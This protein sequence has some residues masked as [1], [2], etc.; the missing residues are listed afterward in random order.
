VRLEST[1][2]NDIV[3]VSD[4]DIDLRASD[5]FQLRN[6]DSDTAEFNETVTL[7]HQRTVT[8]QGSASGLIVESSDDK[9][10]SDYP[11]QLVI[12]RFDEGDGVN[13]AHSNISQRIAS[14]DLTLEAGK[15]TLSLNY[16]DDDNT[17]TENN[18]TTLLKF[19][20][21]TSETADANT[22]S[23]PDTIELGA[24]LD[25]N[26]QNITSTSNGNIVIE[27]DGTGVTNMKRVRLGQD[28][29]GIQIESNNFNDMLATTRQ[30]TSHYSYSLE[31]ASDS[32]ATAIAAGQPGGAFGFT[33][34]SDGLGPF[35]IGSINGVV[36]DEGTPGSAGQNNNGI[37]LYTYEDNSSYAL[38]TVA[39]FRYATSEFM[40]GELT[41][42][43]AS[44]KITIEAPTS[45][46]DI[47]LKTNGS[48]YIILSNLPTS[49]AGLPTGAVW[50]DSGTLKIA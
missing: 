7:I 28:D 8:P 5:S 41:F 43:Y 12:R 25:V 36:G 22:Q 19:K 24:N 27:P 14:Y 40:Q 29:G 21:S 49:S 20:N 32:G 50:N 44:N 15:S 48:G 38:N 9:V 18:T 39:E 10:G 47:E 4:D 23:A 46:N 3:L 30:S 45:G 33:H 11:T 42:D 6:K 37:R 31:V 16:V 2:G 1:G 34:K 17:G 35:Y 26:G 13:T